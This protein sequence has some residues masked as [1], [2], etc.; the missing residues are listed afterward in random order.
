MVVMTFLAT[1]SP[2]PTLRVLTFFRCLYWPCLVRIVLYHSVYHQKGGLSLQN[3]TKQDDDWR[4]KV[5]NIVYQYREIDT[6]F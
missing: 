1:L 5:L 4:G 2:N 3:I 6:K